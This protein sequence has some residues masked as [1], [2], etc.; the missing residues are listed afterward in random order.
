MEQSFFFLFRNR[1]GITGTLGR[2]LH[3]EISNKKALPSLSVCRWELYTEC[4]SHIDI[5]EYIDC[6]L[7]QPACLVLVE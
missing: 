7:A 5:R 4:N 1:E 3:P 6:S 2:N